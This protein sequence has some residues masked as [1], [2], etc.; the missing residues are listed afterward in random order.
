MTKAAVEPGTPKTGLAM[1]PGLAKRA[2]HF[3]AS[4]WRSQ[5]RWIARR[6]D[7]EPGASA[8][9]YR[10]PVAGLVLMFFV[11]SLV[12][13]VAVDLILPWRGAIRIALL[14]LGIWGAVLVLGIFASIT[15]YPHV[16]RPAGLRVRYGVGVDIQIPWDAIG[17]VH[18]GLRP[19]SGRTVQ[20][21]GDALNVVV[22]GQTTVQVDL[23]RPVTVPVS[24]DRTAEIRTLR[25]HGD[26][27]AGMVTAIRAHLTATQA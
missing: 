17:G 4:M 14:V 7:V 16:V 1:V 20:L 21:D 13:V 10:S 27:P 12:E 5:A 2:I 3:E 22:G 26:D 9:A 19:H 8:F 15:V 23:T 24:H 6:P 25:F 11:I 18:R